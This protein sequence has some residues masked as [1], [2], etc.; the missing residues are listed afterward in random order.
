MNELEQA[1]QDIDRI[2]R[3]M[4]ALFEERMQAVGRV[5]LY[6]QQNDLP[7]LDEGRETRVIEKNRGLIRDSELRD[8][9][10]EYIRF[11]MALSRR[12]QAHLLGK[13]PE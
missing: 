10:E 3:Q 13:E 4:A 1:R 11:Q 8:L 6:K 7:I 5:A 2:D 12:Y 9:Y